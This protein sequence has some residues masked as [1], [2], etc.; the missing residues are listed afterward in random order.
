MLAVHCF[1]QMRTPAPFTL[2]APLAADRYPWPSGKGFEDGDIR[3]DL[4]R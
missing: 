1:D 2:D 3:I 4:K